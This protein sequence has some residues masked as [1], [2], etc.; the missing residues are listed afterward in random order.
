MASFHNP[1]KKT[2]F[3]RDASFVNFS[4][5]SI[6]GV[7]L[8]L[9]FG[10]STCLHR[11]L[12]FAVAH[13]DDRVLFRD[14]VAS[15]VPEN[16]HFLLDRLTFLEWRCFAPIIFTTSVVSAPNTQTSEGISRDSTYWAGFVNSRR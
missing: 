16:W 13:N 11:A 1:T 14:I 8:I 3:G 6:R 15:I 12:N 9:P 5:V 10:T 4:G 2:L 7:F